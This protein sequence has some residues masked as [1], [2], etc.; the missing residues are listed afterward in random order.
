MRSICA[1]IARRASPPVA[2][3]KSLD[4]G[5]WVGILGLVSAAIG[6]AAAWFRSSQ[7]KVHVRIDFVEAEM[8]EWSKVNAAQD[9]QLE[10]VK[11]CQ[12]NTRITLDDLKDTTKDTNEKVSKLSETVTQVLLALQG[13]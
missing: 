7:N 12:E 1:C 2:D 4:V 9:V 5:E 10:R 6:T 8:K 13:K 11:T 3:L